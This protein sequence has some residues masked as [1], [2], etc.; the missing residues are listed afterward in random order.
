MFWNHQPA[1]LTSLNNAKSTRI[2]AIIH[3]T[4][5]YGSE[6][7]LGM[8]RPW[9]EEGRLGLMTLGEHSRRVIQGRMMKV[10][11]EKGKVW[12]EGIG[13]WAFVPVS[14]VFLSLGRS[15]GSGERVGMQVRRSSPRIE[16][17][18]RK[19]SFG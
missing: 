16:A 13:V 1:L 10:G 17:G 8:I 9:A 5:H 19:A 2:I 4:E 7:E 6:A 3:E 18:G 15:S 12:W 11:W 14:T